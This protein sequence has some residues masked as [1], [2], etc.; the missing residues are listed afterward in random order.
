M[1]NCTM[2]LNKLL[3]VIDINFLDKVVDKYNADYKVHKLTTK[4]HLLYLLYFHLTEKKSLA[5]FVVNLKVDS[6]LKKEL[7]QISV[8]QL[9]R[10]NENRSY[11]IFADIFSHLFDK[12]KNKQG[13]KETIKDIGSIK[14]IDSSIISLCLS[15]FAWAKFR[16]SKGGIKL[17]TLYDAESGAPENIIVT[18]AIVHDKEIF[19][20]LTFDSG[21]TYIFNRAY[22]DYQK[23]DYFIEN[24]I[25]FVTRTKSNT[26]IEVVRTLEPTK[27]DKKANILL[28]ADVILGS[29][30]KRMKHELRLIKVKT[31]DRQGNEKEIKII[32]NRFDLPAHQIAQLYKERWEIELFFKWIKQHLKIK[33]FFGHNKNAVLIQIYSA[34][35]L[36]LLLKLIKKK[37]KFNGSLLNLTRRIKYSILT[38]VP[39]AFNWKD[40]CYSFS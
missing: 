25:Y 1:N 4:V 36:Y 18:N 30:D 7:P 6:N 14:I 3:E 40:W 32:T 31:I 20:N 13:F 28:D 24:D 10:K 2:L 11:Q 17:H 33:R 8:S 23:F 29:T 9:S 38:I 5:D 39:D 19:D 22:I 35:I 26:K 27:D 34:V 37:A 15:L 16:K 12:L 21:C